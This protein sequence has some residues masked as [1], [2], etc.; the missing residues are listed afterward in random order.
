MRSRKVELY[1]ILRNGKLNQ[2]P[3]VEIVFGEQSMPSGGALSNEDDRPLVRALEDKMIEVYGRVIVDIKCKPGNWEYV[4]L[5]AN[6]LGV[7]WWNPAVHHHPE[8]YEVDLSNKMLRHMHMEAL[9]AALAKYG[10]KR[11]I[12]KNNLLRDEGA[13]Q[14]AAALRGNETLEWLR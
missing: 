14:L 5:G 1:T 6:T 11:L 4:D 10:V 7:D 12:L 9:G 13:T 8:V 3:K 2:Y